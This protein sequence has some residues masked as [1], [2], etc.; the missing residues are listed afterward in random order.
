M[1]EKEYRSSIEAILFAAGDP[2]DIKRLAETLEIPESA[3]KTQLDILIGEYAEMER[4]ITIIQL[5]DTYQMVSVKQF[6]P[7]VRKAMDLRRNIPLSQAAM[8]V[9]AVIAY[10]QPVTKSFV[11]Q[12][13]GVDCSGVIGSLTTKGL[14]EEK[15]RLE[16]PGRPLLY[17]TTDHFLRCFSIRSLDELPPIPKDEDKGDRGK[18]LSIFEN[19]QGSENEKGSQPDTTNDGDTVT[20]TVEEIFAEAVEGK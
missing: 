14:I 20:G 18:Q 10:N 15:G 3:V 9:L 11:E 16:L 8:E 12:V 1:T 4:G 17:G 19:E 2:V 13:R 7:Q 5:N 6:A